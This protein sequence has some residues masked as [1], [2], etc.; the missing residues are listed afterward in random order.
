MVPED[1]LEPSLPKETD[2]ELVE[3][4][5]FIYIISNLKYIKP[6]FIQLF[7]QL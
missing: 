2:F 6:I 7:I 4:I 5:F 3:Y 1:G